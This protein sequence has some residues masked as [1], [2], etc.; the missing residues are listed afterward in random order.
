MAKANFLMIQEVT[1]YTTFVKANVLQSSYRP[2]G[3]QRVPGS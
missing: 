2:G 1:I 3:A